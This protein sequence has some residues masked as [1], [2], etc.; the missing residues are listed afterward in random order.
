MSVP[1]PLTPHITVAVDGSAHAEAA[2]RWA[3]R[4]ATA[5]HLPLRIVNA[6]LPLPLPG[7]R[8]VT[9]EES[10]DILEKAASAARESAPGVEVTT[11]DVA[12]LVG[13]ALA[14]ESET[15]TMLVLGSRG[16]GG[17]RSLLLGSTSLAAATLARCPAVIV[18]NSPA[19][20]EPA[21]RDVVL[22]LDLRDA[23]AAVLQFAFETTAAR[24]G[25]RLRIVHGWTMGAS[26]VAGGPVFD[27]DA[28]HQAVTRELAEV[29]AGW[30]EKYPQVELLRTTVRA[31]PAAALVDASADAA[32]TIV[33][34]RIAGTST[35]MRLGSVAHAVLLHA[36]SPVA[37]VPY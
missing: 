4:E 34:R 22:G 1:P 13:S 6:W 18:R 14:T 23:D 21:P 10:L 2:V 33:G 3:A 31:T 30:S 32:L 16:R 12:D 35:G 37:V 24:P 11:Y 17:F 5:R 28:V 20:D 36:E 15:A 27:S 8:P 7:G 25:A 26:A 19:D 29:C 9:S